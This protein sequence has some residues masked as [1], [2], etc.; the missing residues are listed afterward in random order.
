MVGGRMTDERSLV[1]TL[2]P[3]A[4]TAVSCTEN[5]VKVKL[6]V[7]GDSDDRI[8]V[9]VHRNIRHFPEFWPEMPSV[10]WSGTGRTDVLYAEAMADS[11]R[12]AS[13]V[14]RR[15][16]LAIS[17]PD[18]LICGDE[19]PDDVQKGCVHGEA[20]YMLALF[21]LM[22][23][24][25]PFYMRGRAVTEKYDGGPGSRIVDLDGL[26]KMALRIC[27]EHRARAVA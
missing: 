17:R 11:L 20:D 18:Y 15:L 10:R 26:R 16:M 1:D 24:D 9:E 5:Y 14:A 4:I 23:G 12:Q 21:V 7:E 3:S 8:T 13:A 2:A 19:D 22:H 27:M 25:E 6:G